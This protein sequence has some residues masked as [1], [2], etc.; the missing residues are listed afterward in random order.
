VPLRLPEARQ[1]QVMQAKQEHWQ[2]AVAEHEAERLQGYLLLF[3][4]AVAG[5][6]EPHAD[7]CAFADASTALLEEL[8]PP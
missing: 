3:A 1:R 8:L 6:H 7:P 2:R 5:A 4:L